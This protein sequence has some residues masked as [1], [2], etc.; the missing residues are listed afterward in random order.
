MTFDDDFARLH[1]MHF[2]TPN[3]T[4]KDLD[5]EWPPPEI[6]VMSDDGIREATKDDDRS[7]MLERISMSSITDEQREGMTNVARGAEYL[8]L[9]AIDC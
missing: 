9:K 8:Y 4:L 5:L 7:F 2:G 3:I 6:L 1:L